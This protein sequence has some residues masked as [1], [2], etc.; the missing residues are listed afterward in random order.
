MSDNSPPGLVTVDMLLELHGGLVD[1]KAKQTEINRRLGNLED[2]LKP[3]PESLASQ[4]WGYF[5]QAVV[6][7]IGITVIVVVGGLFGVEVRW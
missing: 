7:G 3:E 4:V 2:A 5:L 6:W 1:L